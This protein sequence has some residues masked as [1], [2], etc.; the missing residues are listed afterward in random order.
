MLAVPESSL[1]DDLDTMDIS[2]RGKVTYAHYSTAVPMK[3]TQLYD[4]CVEHNLIDTSS[5]QGDMNGCSE[6]SL[7]SCFDE[8][9]KKIRHNIYSLGAVIPK[10][11]FPLD[12][13]AIWLIKV[14]PPNNIFRKIRDRV[15]AYHITHTIFKLPRVD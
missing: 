8:K 13:I 11:P 4:Y 3:G 6:Q 2:K 14:V 12:K 7:L 15:Y 9:E 10:L 1:Q 5:Y